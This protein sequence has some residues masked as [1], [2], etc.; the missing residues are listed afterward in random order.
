MTLIANLNFQKFLLF[1]DNIVI[2][3]L[4]QQVD[5]TLKK[6]MKLYSEQIKISTTT[7][8]T[9]LK[10]PIL[11]NPPNLHL[12]PP[13]ISPLTSIKNQNLISIPYYPLVKSIPPAK[14]IP[15]QIRQLFLKSSKVLHPRR[16]LRTKHVTVI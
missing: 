14:T 1:E 13:Q 5:D 8:K 16:P 15:Y 9:C 3:W 12:T 4:I 11:K 7:S 2:F 6:S 10:Y